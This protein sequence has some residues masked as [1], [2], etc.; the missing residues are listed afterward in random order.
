MTKTLYDVLEH[1]GK[2]TKIDGNS[3]YY[4]VQSITEDSLNIL[5]SSVG[6]SRP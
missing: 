1:I 3:G 5:Q 6:L 2:F 4:V